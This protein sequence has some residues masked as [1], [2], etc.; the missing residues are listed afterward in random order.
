MISPCA[1]CSR[2][3]YAL[4]N[5]PNRLETTARNT[6]SPIFG[7]DENTV[8]WLVGTT[9][10]FVHG[11]S[12]RRCTSNHQAVIA[13]RIAMTIAGNIERVSLRRLLS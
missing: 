9:P 13:V 8:S 10:C 3:K 1:S 5:K 6:Q 7:A 2:I 11:F 12:R 4:E